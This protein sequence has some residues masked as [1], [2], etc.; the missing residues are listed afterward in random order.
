MTWSAQPLH[1]QYTWAY[2]FILQS[3]LHD[4]YLLKD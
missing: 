1:I 3:S 4:T 2:V